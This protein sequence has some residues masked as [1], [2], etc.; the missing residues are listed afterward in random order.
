MASII[1]LAF[2]TIDGAPAIQVTVSL[3]HLVASMVVVALSLATTLC[4][5]DTASGQ[6][7][8]HTASGQDGST[9]SG[10]NGRQH[11]YKMSNVPG[12]VPDCI[13]IPR[14]GRRYHR[15][16]ACA[17]GSVASSYSPC[18]KCLP[19]CT[20]TGSAAKARSNSRSLWPDE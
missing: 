13:F 17:G 16:Q 3:W 11:A 2:S 4:W 18:S 5:K 20:T 12:E 6:Y 9:A 7:V 14:T 10:Q 1:S 15:L 8:H 19:S